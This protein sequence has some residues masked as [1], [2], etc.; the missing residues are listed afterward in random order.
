MRTGFPPFRPKAKLCDVRLSLAAWVLL[1]G[2]CAAPTDNGPPPPTLASVFG[3]ERFAVDLELTGTGVLRSHASARLTGQDLTLVP[4]PF[5]PPPRS[6]P[7]QVPPSA[8]WDLEARLGTPFSGDRADSLLGRFSAGF[9]EAEFTGQIDPRGLSGQLSVAD[10]HGAGRLEARPEAIVEPHSYPELARRIESAARGAWVEVRRLELNPWRIFIDDLQ[11]GFATCQDDVEVWLCFERARQELAAPALRLTRALAAPPAPAEQGAL[12]SLPADWLWASPAALSSSARIDA[13]FEA[14]PLEA[15]GAVLDLRGSGAADLQLAR[16]LAWLGMPAENLGI[17]AS[18]GYFRGGR[19]RDEP[20][21]SRAP[22]SLFELPP[23]GWPA[24][25]RLD[26]GSLPINRL[27]R[28]RLELILLLDGD[29]G[30]TALA[31][32]AALKQ[33]GRARLVGRTPERIGEVCR[34]VPLGD[35]FELLLPVAYFLDSGGKPLL[36]SRLALDMPADQPRECEL[37]AVGLAL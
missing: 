6:G 13:T 22:E 18:Q 25:L 24:R 26:P 7:S 19:E 11:R 8:P 5:A 3:G 23:G 2:S 20:V 30:P 16:L 34:A 37:A 17:L 4:R 15:R 9:L 36:E 27:A 29:S 10:G 21:A 14:W 35:G 12:R 32:A 31:L 28:P 33:A 1:A